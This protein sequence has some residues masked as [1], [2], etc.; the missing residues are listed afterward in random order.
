M[1][2]QKCIFCKSADVLVI[3]CE[4]VSTGSTFWVECES[5]GAR[6]P[7]SEYKDGAAIHWNA[8]PAANVNP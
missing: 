3:E 7:I 2:P 6:G 5:C 8:V 4:D 1:D